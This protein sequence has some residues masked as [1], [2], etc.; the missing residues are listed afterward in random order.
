MNTE[1]WKDIP[2]YEGHYQAS[3]LGRIKSMPR[4]IR[5]TFGDFNRGEI[6]LKP[7]LSRQG[8]HYNSLYLNGK[9]KKIKVHQ[10]VAMAFLNHIPCGNKMVV[11]HKNFIKIDNRLENLEIVSNREN[12]NRLHLPSTSKYV[13]V[14]RYSDS[15]K[16][17]SFISIDKKQV[18][19][20]KFS[21][22]K[23]ASMYYENA[24][25]AIQEGR[26]ITVKRHEY[27]SKY[28]GVSLDKK[29]KKWNAGIQINGKRKFLGYFKKEL[30]AHLAVEKYKKENNIT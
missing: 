26:E 15:C 12:S 14:C 13:G 27:S 20:G 25:K 22:E 2:G 6:V 5:K 29:L 24:L 17:S 7:V 19:L 28:K 21:T 9:M 8:Y 18:Y 11:N 1:I 3:N 4:V 16:F 23:E 30:D 10:L